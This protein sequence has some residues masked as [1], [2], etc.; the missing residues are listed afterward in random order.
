[1]SRRK[2]PDQVV[3]VAILF[4]LAVAALLYARHRF[5]PPSFGKLG[6]YRADAIPQ[7]AALPV[8]YAGAD[9]CA[10]CHTDEAGVKAKSFHKGL[11]CEVCHGAAKDHTEAPDEHKPAIPRER[12][13]CLY[14]HEYLGSRPTGFPQIIEKAHNPLDPCL[15]CHN[16]H[17]PTPPHVP[18][19]CAACHG[20]IYRTKAVSPHR[21]L[22]C[23]TCH[24]AD[25]K[26]REIPR[27]HLPT[28]PAD[29][30]FCGGCHAKDAKS[31]TS[32]PRID[33]ASHGG[34]YL[35]WQCHYPHD[36]EAGRS[37]SR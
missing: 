17:D 13:D 28:K 33:L 35:C 20:L 23:E 32:I 10:E 9:V 6:H 3:R 34:R 16:P 19:T 31:P 26:H 14:C 21:T 29:K 18:S 8:R 25:P 1:M 37:A 5:T 4:V 15:K 24:K 30:A 36:P 12:R 7:I 11:S 27:A 2:I 22:E